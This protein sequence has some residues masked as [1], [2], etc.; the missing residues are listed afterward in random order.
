MPDTV[1]YRVNGDGYRLFYRHIEESGRDVLSTFMTTL[2]TYKTARGIARGDTVDKLLEAYDD[3]LLWQPEPFPVSR[4]LGGDFCVY[5]ELFVYTRPKDDNC[6]LVFYVASNIK[7][8]FITGIQ[9]SLGQDGGPAFSADEM[10]TFAVDYADTEQ[11][12]KIDTSDEERI[13]QLFLDS[14]GFE[15]D[16][17][18]LDALT[19]INWRI[20]SQLYPDD[21]PDLIGWLYLQ[22][23][24]SEHDILCVLKATKG[25][26]GGLSEGYAGVL[27]NI[28]RHDS[29]QFLRLAAELDDAQIAVVAHLACYDLVFSKTQVTSELEGYRSGGS[30]TEKELLVIDE[31]MYSLK[32]LSTD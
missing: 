1:F 29:R 23:F 28:Y 11:Y 12:L 27:A 3:G 22:T 18:L 20:Y 9:I 16:P 19:D 2:D 21:D 15:A 32:T 24:T 30:L 17:A 4:D 7:S 5:D 25:L 13:H 8:K 6:C 31:I 14:Q 26:D 10:N